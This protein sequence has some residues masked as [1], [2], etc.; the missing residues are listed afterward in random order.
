MNNT[1]L[2]LIIGCVYISLVQKNNSTRNIML[3]ITGL[4]AFCMLGITEGYCTLPTTLQDP[5]R[6]PSCIK[7]L[8]A[9]QTVV[10]DGTGCTPATGSTCSLDAAGDAPTSSC[11]YVDAGPLTTSAND[12]LTGIISHFA[13]CASGGEATLNSFGSAKCISDAGATNVDQSANLVCTDAD[14]PPPTPPPPP[15]APAADYYPCTGNLH[16]SGGAQGGTVASFCSGMTN[17]IVN[18]GSY[19]QGA[20][21]VPATQT[22]LQEACCVPSTS[23]TQAEALD[24]AITAALAASP[25]SVILNE[26][27]YD[28]YKSECERQVAL[29]PNLDDDYD[30]AENAVSDYGQ[31]DSNPKIPECSYAYG[32]KYNFLGPLTGD[33]YWIGAK[34]VPPIS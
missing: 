8:T 34:C 4:L 5:S 23:G 14:T 29:Q 11:V 21:T 18:V 24:A 30:V 28:H 27:L 9:D 15:P 6:Q 3:L 16:T 1:K 17:K 10:G 12:N 33:D 13:K 25:P 19:Y 32:W 22:N 2:I 7:V 26:S 20:G 31:D